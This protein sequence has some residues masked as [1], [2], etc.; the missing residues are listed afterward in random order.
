M[1]ISDVKIAKEALI[2]QVKGIVEEFAA[3]TGVTV[4]LSAYPEY[5]AENKITDT[6]YVNVTLTIN[7]KET[8]K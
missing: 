2:E 8:T 7:T 6:Y 4:G 3:V 1:D 5:S